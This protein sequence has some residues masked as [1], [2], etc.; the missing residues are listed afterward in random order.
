MYKFRL[1]DIVRVNRR[2]E[3]YME[4]NEYGAMDETMGE[5]GIVVSVGPN[6]GLVV[7]D[8]DA[9]ISWNYDFAC[10]DLELDPDIINELS[11][12]DIDQYE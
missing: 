6:S 12:W 7:F 2:V 9:E 10:L 8:P 5:S 3:V 11:T 4:W 1:G